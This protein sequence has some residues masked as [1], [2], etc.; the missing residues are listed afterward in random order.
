MGVPTDEGLQNS[1][2]DECI[3]FLVGSQGERLKC[4]VEFS[5]VPYSRSMHMHEVMQYSAR[6]KTINS[7]HMIIVV[8][9][10]TL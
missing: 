6:G 3:L 10:T 7:D 8:A 4:S 2:M 5:Y 1:I 9:M